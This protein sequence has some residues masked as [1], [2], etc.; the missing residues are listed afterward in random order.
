M[1][2]LVEFR[3]ETPTPVPKSRPSIVLFVTVK[4]STVSREISVTPDP[5][6]NICAPDTPTF[7]LCETRIPTA[8]VPVG[9]KFPPLMMTWGARSVDDCAP[10]IFTQAMLQEVFT[11]L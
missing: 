1:V 11:E 9:K 8:P 3:Q 4:P 10:F 6:G 2:P 5:P 7:V